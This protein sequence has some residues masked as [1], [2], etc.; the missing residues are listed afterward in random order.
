MNQMRSIE[1]RSNNCQDSELPSKKSL[2][3]PLRMHPDRFTCSLHYS[4]NVSSIKASGV[5]LR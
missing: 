2:S 3:V 4:L 5:I 1:D